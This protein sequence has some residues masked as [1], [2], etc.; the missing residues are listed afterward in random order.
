MALPIGVNL[1]LAWRLKPQ[2][3]KQ[4]PPARVKRT[5]IFRQSA[6]ALA[7]PKGRRTEFFS[8]D[9]QS[10]GLKLTPIGNTMPLL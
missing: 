7:F 9:F 2:L 1:T 8:R 6:F 10:P 4:N 3:H 5:L